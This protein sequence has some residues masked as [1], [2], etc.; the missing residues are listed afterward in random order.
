M[1]EA[2][3]GQ[4]VTGRTA[5]YQDGTRTLRYRILAVTE[6]IPGVTRVAAI[7]LGDDDEPVNA[8]SAVRG[9]MLAV[10][11]GKAYHVVLDGRPGVRAGTGTLQAAL[12]GLEDLDGEAYLGDLAERL[13]QELMLREDDEPRDGDS[14]DLDDTHPAAGHMSG[15][16]GS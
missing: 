14:P 1:P 5:T 12:D 13:V 2:V 6:E 10:V 7:R 11:P 4:P 3:D 8:I 9:L 16:Y 15:G